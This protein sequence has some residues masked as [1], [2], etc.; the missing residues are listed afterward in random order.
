[1]TS[2]PSTSA[3]ASGA[4]EGAPRAA[5]RA[6][7]VRWTI[8]VIAALVTAIGLVL[9]FLLAVSTNNRAF[10]EENYTRLF[11]I[12]VVVATLL[13]LVIGWVAVRLVRRLRQGKFGS[14]LLIKLAAIFALVG[15]TLTRQRRVRG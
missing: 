11:G 1:M 7:A 4:G 5:R 8:G 6:K 13:L 9:M 15:T 3:G 12:N 14:R 10:Y 2:R